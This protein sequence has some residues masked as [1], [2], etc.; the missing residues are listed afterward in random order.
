[1]LVNSPNQIQGLVCII[2]LI[3]KL[4]T[5]EQLCVAQECASI[6]HKKLGCLNT[7]RFLIF[8]KAIHG[9]LMDTEHFCL[10]DYAWKGLFYE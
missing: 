5:M 1:M 6:I 8:W 9:L 4:M 10:L 7:V 3:L 2:Y